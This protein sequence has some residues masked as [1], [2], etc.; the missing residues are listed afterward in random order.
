VEFF[1]VLIFSAGEI[2]RH[3]LNWYEPKVFGRKD[4]K[5]VYLKRIGDYGETI[6]EN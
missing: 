6:P 2:F 1:F 3:P 5:E 4:S